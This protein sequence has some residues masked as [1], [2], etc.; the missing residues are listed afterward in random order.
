MNKVPTSDILTHTVFS[1]VKT[2]GGYSNGMHEEDMFVATA[3]AMHHH[4]KGIM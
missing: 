1:T 4:R 2:K 3:S